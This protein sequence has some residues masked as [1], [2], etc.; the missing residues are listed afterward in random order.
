MDGSLRVYNK[1]VKVVSKPTFTSR[2]RLWKWLL[3][4]ASSR[5]FFPSLLL[6]PLYLHIA[7]KVLLGMKINAFIWS[8]GTCGALDFDGLPRT[9]AL[10]WDR[11]MFFF[12][13]EVWKQITSSPVLIYYTDT[14]VLLEN[15]PLVKFIR[16][17]IRNLKDFTDIKFV[18]ILLKFV[19]VWSKHLRVFL[20]SLRQS[21][22][23]GRKCSENHQKRRYK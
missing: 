4:Q 8:L 14:N 13:H 9:G 11:L 5:A 22:E 12:C 10:R 2:F 17:Y 15:T 6:F 20:E 7:P 18:K 19:D 16:I 1:V 23:S 3:T 21:S